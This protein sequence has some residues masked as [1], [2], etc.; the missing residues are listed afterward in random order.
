VAEIVVSRPEEPWSNRLRSY[1][2]VIDGE[3]LAS[4]GRG[5]EATVAVAAG[6]HKVWAKIDWCRSGE[7]PLD[8]GE[9]ARAYLRCQSS[10]QPSFI[11]PKAWLYVTIRRKRYLDLRLLR[12][13]SST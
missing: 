7:V 8:L 13:E 5:Q 11:F 1:K 9:N 6:H 12:V 4:L 10:F 2:I 3:T